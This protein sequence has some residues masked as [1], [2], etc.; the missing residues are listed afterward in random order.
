MPAWQASRQPTA[1]ILARNPSGL[2][3]LQLF[4]EVLAEPIGDVIEVNG[5]AGDVFLVHPWLFHTRSMN[6]SGKPRLMSNTEAGLK[7]PMR[8]DRL[9]GDDSVLET[10][11]KLALTESP[12]M[13]RNAFRARF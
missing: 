6:H 10:S 9:G 8:F 11:I 4:E 13:P 7:E 1:R 5:A 3:H 12:R 2:T